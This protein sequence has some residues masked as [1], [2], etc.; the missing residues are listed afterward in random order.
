MTTAQFIFQ[1]GGSSCGC[2]NTF[3]DETS[4]AT[5]LAATTASGA[6]LLFD[7]SSNGSST[8]TFTTVGTLNLGQFT[9][10]Q[11]AGGTSPSRITLNFQ[12]G[13]TLPYAPVSINGSINVQS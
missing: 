11:N 8:Y 9:T 12:N 3:T 4:L 5:A 2:S 13:T 6:L 10:W 7:L 1:P